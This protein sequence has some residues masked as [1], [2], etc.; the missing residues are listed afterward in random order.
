MC[1]NKK[2]LADSKSIA[3]VWNLCLTVFK[4]I[5][6]SLISFVMIVDQS[7]RSLGL[8]DSG[9]YLGVVFASASDLPPF[10]KITHARLRPL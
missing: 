3:S 4:K 5:Q 6:N 7:V 9:L 8:T 10:L 2:T 1:I